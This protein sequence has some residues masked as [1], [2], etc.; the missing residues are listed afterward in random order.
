MFLCVRDEL[1]PLDRL[2]LTLIVVSG[3]TARETAAPFL[4]GEAVLR[5]HALYFVARAE[6]LR[7]LGRDGDAEQAFSRAM[8]CAL[9]EPVARHLE[10][11]PGVTLVTSSQR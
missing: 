7:M 2:A 5:D 4:A 8:A 9:S 11:L 10:R 3:F 6:V 1:T